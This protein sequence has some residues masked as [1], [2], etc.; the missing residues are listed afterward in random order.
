MSE[1]FFPLTRAR[2]SGV[3]HE[4]STAR[5]YIRAK[6]VVLTV[7]FSA[8]ALHPPALHFATASTHR[9]PTT[10]PDSEKNAAQLTSSDSHS[11]PRHSITLPGDLMTT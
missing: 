2:T 3:L 11:P 1:S 6:H 4:G 9:H 7:S 8:P 5:V 10:L